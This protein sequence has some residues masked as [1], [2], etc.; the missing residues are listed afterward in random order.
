MVARRLA[1]PNN[2]NLP[3]LLSELRSNPHISLEISFQFGAPKLYARL[4]HSIAT[5]AT[6]SVPETSVDKNYLAQRPKHDVGSSGKTLV[7]HR[8]RLFELSKQRA[9]SELGLGVF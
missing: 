6:V 5:R 9:H 3:L 2:Q 1:F 8:I 7:V 4:R